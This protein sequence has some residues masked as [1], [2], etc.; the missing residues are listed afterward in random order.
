MVVRGKHC[1][2]LTLLRN[3]HKL[4]NYPYI[5]TFLAW[6][7]VVTPLKKAG[8]VGDGDADDVAVESAMRTNTRARV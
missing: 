4:D 8:E 3:C 7:W 2:K 6:P 1:I 5:G